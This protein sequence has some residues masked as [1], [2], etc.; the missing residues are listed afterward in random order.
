MKRASCSALLVVFLASAG[1]ARS[2][3]FDRLEGA[4]LAGVLSTDR[5]APRDRLTVSD[6]GNLRGAFRD[7]RSPVLIVRTSEG[8][9]TRLVVAHGFRK[10]PG[11]DSASP[12]VV[13]ERFE[14]F[15]T[16]G[17]MNRIARGRGVCLFDG[18]RYDLDSG[19]VVPEGQG[20]D[21]QFLAKGEGGPRLVVDGSAKL[22]ALN[23]S[24]LTDVGARGKRPS[25]GR[26]IAPGD[27]SGRYRLFA[28][29]QLSGSLEMTVDD[30]GAA[31]GSFRSDQTGSVYS[32]SGQVAPESPGLIKFAV[33]F[34]RSRQEFDAYLWTEGKGALAGTSTLVNIT[35]GFFALRDGGRFSPEDEDVRS[36]SAPS[37]APGRKDVMV[38]ADGRFVIDGRPL[39]LNGFSDAIKAALAADPK[40]W[41][42]LKI[43]SSTPYS[44]VARLLQVA[45][46]LGV[47]DARV[48][49]VDGEPTKP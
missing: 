23:S 5:V 8:N 15:E 37:D 18:F 27:F 44:T 20:G 41:V 28:N 21:L 48:I 3:D 4:V 16:P 13:L 45:R 49:P 17:A 46:M 2:D 24:P 42:A 22:Y 34:P 6:L 47:A 33:I 12:I 36:T 9:L 35:F 10:A 39:D 11:G 31:S 26:A 30:Q 14:T 25:A 7:M 29:G 1:A 38:D 40:T 19:Q 43:A 32:I